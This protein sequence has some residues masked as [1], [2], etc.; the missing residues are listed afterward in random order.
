MDVTHGLVKFNFII[1]IILVNETEFLKLGYAFKIK[2]KNFDEKV[3]K[4]LI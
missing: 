4:E 1:S 3:L 2:L